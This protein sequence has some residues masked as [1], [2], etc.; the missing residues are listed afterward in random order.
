M[1]RLVGLLFTA[2]V[3]ALAADQVPFVAV[4]TSS[5]PGGNLPTCTAP[6]VPVEGVGTGHATHLGLFTATQT[7]C[8]SLATGAFTSGH[9]ILTGANG[10]AISGTHSGQLVFTSPATAAINGV[11]VITGGTG[12]FSSASGGGVATGNLDLTTQEVTDFVMRGTIS[13]PNH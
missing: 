8:L 11:F 12:R 1:K 4:F 3:F 7:H 5:I 13:R 10:D 9:F 6:L 2:A